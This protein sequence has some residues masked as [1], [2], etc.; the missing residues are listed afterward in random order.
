MQ[1]VYLIDQAVVPN[2]TA[3]RAEYNAGRAPGEPNIDTDEAFVVMRMNRMLREWVQK[4]G[5]LPPQPPAPDPTPE[6]HVVTRKQG[7]K[8]LARA[9]EPDVGLAAPIYEADIQAKIDAM[10]STT[11]ADK[12]A[13][14]DMQ[15]EFRDAPT[16]RR[17]NQFF[18][19]MVMAMNITPAQRDALLQL[20]YSFQE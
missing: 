13:K 2:V 4:H 3:E 6:W 9:N 1:V 5:K 11:D 7:L 20:A 8:A 14:Y 17:G 12:L 16:W 15:V 10:P 19:S 18:E